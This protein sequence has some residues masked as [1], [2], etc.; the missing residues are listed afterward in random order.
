MKITSWNVRG[1]NTPNK[2]CLLRHFLESTYSDLWLIQETKLSQKE[3]EKFC[4]KL[5]RWKSSRVNS[6]GASR[7]LITLWRPQD[8][9]VEEVAKS[10][11]GITCKVLCLASNLCF[12]L[13]NIYGPNSYLEK[14]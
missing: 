2:R 1:L 13:I 14:K 10:I 5:K 4:K 6:N 9:L 11:F 3:R 8:I 7:D 12:L